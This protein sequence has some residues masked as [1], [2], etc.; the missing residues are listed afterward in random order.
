MWQDL[1]VMVM[2]LSSERFHTMI[3]MVYH[4]NDFDF[5]RVKIFKYIYNTSELLFLVPIHHALDHIC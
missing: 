5:I 2:M 3:I 4:L 1:N